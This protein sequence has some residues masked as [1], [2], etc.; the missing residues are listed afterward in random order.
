MPDIT[1]TQA[2][3]A[4]RQLEKDIERLLHEFETATDLLLSGVELRHI[5][6]GHVGDD[7]VQKQLIGVTVHVEL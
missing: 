2:M 4:R 6:F 3:V 7:H 1:V 5:T